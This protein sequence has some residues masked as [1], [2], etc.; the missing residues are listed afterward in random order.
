MKLTLFASL[1]LVALVGVV[2][3]VVRVNRDQAVSVGPAL[4][5]AINNKPGVTFTARRYEK[6]EGLSSA[7]LN[8]YLGALKDPKIEAAAI[9]R[10]KREV[11]NNE[12]I[13]LQI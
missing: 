4:V 11:G 13:Y 12:V 1:A 6:F 10:Q 3:G 8:R 5:S 9:S 2:N 7:E